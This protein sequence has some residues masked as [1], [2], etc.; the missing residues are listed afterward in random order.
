MVNG[1]YGFLKIY[2]VMATVA[3]LI[4]GGACSS[5]SDKV[6]GKSGDADQAQ[7]KDDQ[8]EGVEITP[9]GL[10]K[11]MSTPISTRDSNATTLGRPKIVKVEEIKDRRSGKKYFDIVDDRGKNSSLAPKVDKSAR[12]IRVTTFENNSVQKDYAMRFGIVW[13]RV[14]ESFLE[15][16]LNVVDRSSGI[17]ITDWITDRAG[18]RAGMS[19]SLFDAKDKIVRYKYTI[20]ILDRGAMTQIKVIPFTQVSNNKKGWASAKPSL[21][22]TESMFQRIE[23]ELRIPLPSER[24]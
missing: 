23:R 4:S 14:L 7:V 16:P 5:I 22:V 9:K 2:M 10:E 6:L 19:L 15:L 11:G 8:S 12:A 20:R 1:R 21:S 3:I 17:I 18:A 24:D 13:A